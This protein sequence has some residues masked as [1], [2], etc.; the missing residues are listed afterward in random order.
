V[1]REHALAQE[2]AQHVEERGFFAEGDRVLV[3][4]SGGLDS[5]VLLHLL[6]FSP[7]LPSLD[8]RVGHFDHGMR[9]GS[10]GDANWVRGVA[11]AWGLEYQGGRSR[12]TLSSEEDAREARFEF[13]QGDLRSGGGRWIVTAH[14]A[15]DQAE[16]VLFRIVRGTGLRGLAGI[17][18]VREPGILRPLLPFSKARLAEYAGA[19]GIAPRFDP[20]NDDP[21]FAR[22]VIRNEILPRLEEAVAPGATGSLLRLARIA[23]QEECAWESIVP[24]LLDG[25]IVESGADRVVLDRRA[26]L[27]YSPEVIGR[28]LR[29]LS[30][31]MGVSLDEAGTRA[32]VTFT[33]AGASGKE[34]WISGLLRVQRAFDHLVIEL[35]SER[36]VDG[37]IEIGEPGAGCG[38]FVIGGQQWSA[39]WSVSDEM[40]GAWVE[41]FSLSE[42]EFPVRMRAWTAGDRVNYSYGSKKLKKVFGEARVPLDKRARTPVVVDGAGH[43]LWVPGVARSCLEAPASEEDAF[44]ISLSTSEAR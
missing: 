35:V 25:L 10:A 1:T 4:V 14:H 13:L 8:L 22:N 34:H 21:A 23:A 31:R 2:F 36:G 37:S 39:I 41:R 26:L 29:T 6:R 18:E 5:L 7:G 43:V 12:T 16:T 27:G 11:R 44:I 38:D 42:L 19:L 15:D 17:P 30:S 24:K 28:L 20:S 32:A 33:S 3:A 40:H 9:E